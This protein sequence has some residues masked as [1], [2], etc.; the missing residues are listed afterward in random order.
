MT[1]IKYLVSKCYSDKDYTKLV[2]ECCH[3]YVMG[4]VTKRELA[5]LNL[6]IKR[7]IESN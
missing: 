2:A 4:E 6:E 3:K 5:L 1:E 7:Q